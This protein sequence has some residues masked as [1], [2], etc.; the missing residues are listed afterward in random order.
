[1]LLLLLQVGDRRGERRGGVQPVPGAEGRAQRQ[2]VEAGGGG[3]HVHGHG[4]HHSSR[5]LTRTT[6]DGG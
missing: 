1:M 3:G 4:H 5:C 6:A 2:A